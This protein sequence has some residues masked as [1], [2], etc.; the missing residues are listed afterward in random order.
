MT[1]YPLLFALCLLFGCGEGA[2][3]HEA[4]NL[5]T[6]EG[7]EAF[8]EQY[9]E[10]VEAADLRVTIEKLRYK[11]AMDSRNPEVLRDYLARHPDGEFVAKAQ[12]L[13]DETSWQVADG[14]KTADAYKS[15][16]D[17]HPEGRWIDEATVAYT[18]AAYAEQM[19]V[20]EATIAKVNMAQDPAGPLNGWGVQAEVGNPG[21][22]RLSMVKMAID[23]LGATGDV[24]R[25][26]VW[27]T[28]VQ[29]L[30][31]MPV[32]P[33][34]RPIMEPGETR[35]FRWT[36]AESPPG[37]SEGSFAVRVTAVRVEEAPT[38]SPEDGR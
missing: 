24:V 32:Q 7:Y 10:S 19:T 30:G 28:V 8:L 2:A 38:S 37:W 3:L 15:Y 29:D 6:P 21:D 23:S 26:D 11:R 34:L 14:T 13:E 35:T 20:G 18:K 16:V 22:Q 9:P 12:K 5:R 17:L 27:Y 4:Q 36:T 25:T 1:R 31:P 33:H